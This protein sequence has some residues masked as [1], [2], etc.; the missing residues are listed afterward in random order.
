MSLPMT[1]QLSRRRFLERAGRSVAALTSVTAGAPFVLGAAQDHTPGLTDVPRID[2]SLVVDNVAL[3][4]ASTDLGRVV[5]RRPRAVLRPGSIADIVR[6]VEYANQKRLPVVMRG[7]GHSR[8]GLALVEDGIVIDSR[9][10][11]K[12]VT[13]THETID[14]EAGC[15]LAALVRGAAD[16][17]YRVPVM[18][19]CTMLSVGGFASVGGQSFGSHTFGAFV[20]TVH[21]LDVVTGDGRLV[22]CSESHER[23]LFEMTLAGLGQCAIVVRVRLNLLPAAEQVTTRTIV[24]DAI[25]PFLDDQLRLL[26]AEG[27][28]FARGSIVRRSGGAWEYRLMLGMFGTANR[29]SDPISLLPA[30]GRGRAE[31]AVRA[32]FRAFFP[33]V[34]PTSAQ[35]APPPPTGAPTPSGSAPI[36]GPSLAVWLPASASGNLVA[37]YLASEDSAGI[38]FIECTALPTNRFRRPLFRVPSEERM[39]A[40]WTLRSVFANRGPALDAQLKANEAFL[41]RALAMG[42]KRYP[43]YGGV[44]GAAEWKTHYGERLYNRFAD[45]KRKYDPRGIL[46]PGPGVFS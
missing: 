11:N 37:A 6:I 10:L 36:A 2:G 9:S 12:V 38:T 17:G 45:A 39:F 41:H 18:T 42:A 14:V 44:L 40:F 27:L 35:A 25:E 3:R 46:T 21:E 8:Y 32:D 19:D 23:E 31:A 1:N 15:A 34:V 33:G 4:A 43:P 13:V 5:T 26:S 16:A 29:E 28:D 7:R 24:Y 30:Q 22:T 20:D